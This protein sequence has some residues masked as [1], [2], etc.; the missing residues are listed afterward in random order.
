M[1]RC[2]G[3]YLS[4]IMWQVICHPGS[5][6]EKVLQVAGQFKTGKYPG[7]HQTFPEAGSPNVSVLYAPPGFAC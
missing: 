3:A 4:Y 1:I 7:A 6:G 5:P 2:P